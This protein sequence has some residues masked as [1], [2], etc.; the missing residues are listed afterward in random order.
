[1]I[2]ANGCKPRAEATSAEVSTSAEAPSEI[3]LAFAAVIVPSL[4]MQ[5]SNLEFYQFLHLMV[6]H[7]DQQQH[8][9][10]G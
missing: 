8:H 7:L 4:Q 9:L 5:V 6:V 3:E 10:Y 2:F 1:M